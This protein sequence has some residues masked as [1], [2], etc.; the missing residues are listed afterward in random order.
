MIS[1]HPVQDCRNHY[2]NAQN[3]LRESPASSSR[4]LLMGNLAE[5]TRRYN[6]RKKENLR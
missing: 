6:Y 5:R 4:A 2:S 3:H 1:V